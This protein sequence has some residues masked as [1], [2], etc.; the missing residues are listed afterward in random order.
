MLGG[1]EFE[2]VGA[3]VGVVGVGVGFGGL[4]LVGVGVGVGVGVDVTGGR[5][6]AFIQ[7]RIFA[8]VGVWVCNIPVPIRM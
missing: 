1:T 2:V 8:D 7:Q 5:N 3:G 6:T 4:G